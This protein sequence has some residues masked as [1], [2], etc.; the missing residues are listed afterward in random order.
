MEPERKDVYDIDKSSIMPGVKRERTIVR[1]AICDDP[2]FYLRG[3]TLANKIKERL[4]Q[5]QD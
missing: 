4:N 5:E 1:P 2:K 3:I